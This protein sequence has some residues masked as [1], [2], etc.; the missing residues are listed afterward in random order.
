ML[1]FHSKP[2]FIDIYFHSSLLSS[3]FI[4]SWTSS[5]PLAFV[6]VFFLYILFYDISVFIF[7]WIFF[8]H[9][10]NKSTPTRYYV[11]VHHF[12]LILVWIFW[13]AKL[14]KKKNINLG[15][16]FVSLLSH[17]RMISFSQWALPASPMLLHLSLI[18]SSVLDH[19][20]HSH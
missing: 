13:L 9:L 14:T 7:Q 2:L 5:S 8:L 20:H 19:Q 6:L 10:P 18:W 15:T 17:Y 3:K 11:I 1:F 4:T 16:K 12:F